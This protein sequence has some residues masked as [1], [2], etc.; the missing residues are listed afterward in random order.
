MPLESGAL[1]FE[2]RGRIDDAQGS[3]EIE[4]ELDE[5]P[6]D[7]ELV[8]AFGQYEPMV[9]L[10]GDAVGLRIYHHAMR[11]QMGWK[12]RM[13]YRLR[14]S[15]DHTFGFVLE[16]KP[17]G[18]PAQRLARH[19][20][21][22]AFRQKYVPF[23]IGGSLAG[24]PVFTRWTGSF[25]GWIRRVRTW[26]EPVEVPGPAI[27]VRDLPRRRAP[28][29]L[30]ADVRILS[31]HDPPIHDSPWRCNSIPPRLGDLRRTRR[32]ARLDELVAPCENELEVF[33]KLTWYVSRL[34]PHFYY[35]PWPTD[36]QR[37]IFW[38]RGHEM[39]PRIKAGEMGGMCGGFAHVM[40]ELFWA[41]GFDARR[42][43][44]YGHSTFEAYSNQFD[45]WMICDA[46]HSRNCYYLVDGG[47]VPQNTMDLIRRHER[48]VSDPRA[49]DDIRQAVC[50]EDGSAR[51]IETTIWQAYTH[52][53]VGR[54]DPNKAQGKR[55]HIWY[56]SPHEGPVFDGSM[57]VGGGATRVERLE[58]I[59]WSCNRAQV[60]LKWI[61]P[62]RKLEVS[63]RPFQVTFADG[64]E[65]EI[66]EEGWEKCAARFVWP[67]HAGVNALRIRTRNR[68]GAAGH[69]WGIQLWRRP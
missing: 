59:Y 16:V 30:P 43:Q 52:V 21:W 28:F 22:R 55:P 4:F 24:S 13:P 49:F 38:K 3:L 58:D 1:A 54:G 15:W 29:T 6:S 69:P 14:V 65:R 40:E 68:L 46:S 62:G 57:G 5:K 41:M 26:R 35:W 20:G 10:T 19:C 34:W 63:L 25:R 60:S 56:L 66:D 48:R 11:I 44:V 9:Q 42:T 18:G 7:F 50:Q 36:E 64:F 33:A 31:L 8:H 45:K 32:A 37:H 47:G 2:S 23:C 39:I 67:L 12:P 17:R 53:G 27:Q 61:A 51:P